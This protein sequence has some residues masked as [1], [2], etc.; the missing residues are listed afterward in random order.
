MKGVAAIASGAVLSQVIIAIST[1]F[2]ARLYPPSAYGNYTVIVSL[3][4]AVAPSVTLKFDAG[5]IIPREQDTARRLFRLSL[6]S[7]LIGALLASAVV[8]FLWW[9]RTV[10]TL[11][12]IPLA[13]L[14]VGLMILLSAAFLTLTQGALRE[15]SYG[16]VARR[17]PI[18]SLGT[19]LSQLILSVVTR[20]GVGLLLGNV[21]G[22]SMGFVP[23]VKA[24]KDLRVRPQTSTYRAVAREFRRLPAI[25]APSGIIGDLS[26]QLPT[27]IVG[28]WFGSVA[29][30]QM[31]MAQR[32]VSIP[33]ITIGGAIG[34]VFAAE[35]ASRFRQGSAGLNRYYLRA[36]AILAGVAGLILIVFISLSRQLFPLILGPNWIVA[37]QLAQVL[38][39]GSAA[40]I[41]GST[42]SPV[43]TILQSRSWIV[44]SVI[45]M[46][47]TLGSAFI[48]HGIGL[49]L[50]ATCGAFV[51]AQAV[52]YSIVWVVGWRLTSRPVP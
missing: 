7:A 48:A 43:F 29:V 5:I 12:S 50:V 40:A 37:G 44:V 6:T 19:T 34:Q 24:T 33:I 52:H 36:S 1:I 45:R 35:F 22:S 15:S 38:C 21:I 47:L 18:Q 39:V 32:I 46:V 17:T 11:T 13:P 31:G 27:L 10:P 25:M 28:T 14:W 4:A 9:T 41:I 23:L 26:N 42:V 16:V 20:S 51:V 49:S 3:V 8:A 30:G 2:L